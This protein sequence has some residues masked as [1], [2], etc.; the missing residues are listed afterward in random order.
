MPEA[1]LRKERLLSALLSTTK[2]RTSSDKD[3][4]WNG[5]TAFIKAVSQW[6]LPTH[7]FCDSEV[8][9]FLEG[10]CSDEIRG[11]HKI[12]HFSGQND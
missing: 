4:T 3:Y 8:L 10:I 11:L 12:W 2:E 6:P 7:G 5:M 1:M 9:L